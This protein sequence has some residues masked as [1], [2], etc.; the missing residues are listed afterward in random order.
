[1]GAEAFRVLSVRHEIVSV[2]QPGHRSLKSFLRPIAVWAG[3]KKEDTLGEV[4]RK[5]RVPH[6]LASSRGDPA[7]LRMLETSS[8]DIICIAA[9]RWVLRPEIYSIPPFGAINVHPSLLPKYRGRAPFFWVYYN[10]ERFTGVTVHQVIEQADAGPI[11]AQQAFD[12]PRGWAVDAM[13]NRCA[14]LGATML[15][16]VC[17]QIENQRAV[18]LPQDESRATAAPKIAPGTRMIDFTAWPAERVWHFLA[19]LSPHYREPLLDSLHQNVAYRRAV[20]YRACVQRSVAPGT[21][22]SMSK[23]WLL[24]CLDGVVELSA[25]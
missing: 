15:V 3:L 6:L 2:V 24:Q 4:I 19:G 5:L 7:V 21:A 14:Q 13:H 17:D 12:V 23:G 22:V 18:Y 9:Y 8:P 1:M 20:G 11:L 16:E 25:D 10:D